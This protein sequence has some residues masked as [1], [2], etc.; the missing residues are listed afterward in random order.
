MIFKKG[1]LIPSFVFWSLLFIALIA[2][3]EE[4]APFIGVPVGASPLSLWSTGTHDFYNYISS[5]YPHTMIVTRLDELEFPK[6][7]KHC[8]FITISPEL[9]YTAEESAL[10][11]ERLARCERPALLIAD[12]FN[13]SNTLLAAIGSS[14]RITGL[15][16]FVNDENLGLPSP[17][18]AATFVLPS[19]EDLLL[20]L[21]RASYIEG[22]AQVIGYVDHA[23]AIDTLNGN[24]IPVRKAPVAVYESTGHFKAVI[25]SDGS[26]F[27]NQVLRSNLSNIYLKTLAI[28]I[29]ELC[30]KSRDC[31]IVFDSSK[32][33]TV[34]AENLLQ[35]ASSGQHTLAPED[36]LLLALLYTIKLIH[37]ST[38][39]VHVMKVVG[40]YT[41]K[42]FTAPPLSYVSIVITTVLLSNLVLQRV[43]LRTRDDKMDE[44]REVEHLVTGDIINAITKGKYRLERKDFISLYEI[45]DNTLNY[46]LGCSLSDPGVLNILARYIGEEPARRYVR[47]MTRL[48]MKATG[49]SRLPLVISWS[50]VVKKHIEESEKIFNSIGLTLLGDKGP[51]YVPTV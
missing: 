45:V 18:V 50:R 8:L 32:Y 9:P 43:G 19:G 36:L 34:D 16:L 40:D 42:A 20:I 37:P 51:E 47:N 10:I 4:G 13:T 11:V 15:Q 44:V 14:A 6:N 49:R 23:I 3:A 21:D 28:Y 1:L 46:A 5:K 17:F 33:V 48:Y 2:M 24:T 38:W 29:D 31:R 41:L 30:E 25:I 35:S 12:E 22:G 27:L 39:F 7:A 26:I